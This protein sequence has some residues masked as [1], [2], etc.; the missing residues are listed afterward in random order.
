MNSPLLQLNSN[1]YNQYLEFNQRIKQIRE[2]YP[3]SEN[4]YPYHTIEIIPF[5]L[6]T[7]ES[8][9]LKLEDYIKDK[10]ILDLGCGDGDL[11]FFFEF[12]GAKTVI[13][14]D[15]APTNFNGLKGFKLIKEKL[16]SNVILIEGDIHEFNFK[17][18]P[19]IDTAFVFGFLYHSKHPLWILENLCKKTQFLFLTTKVFDH[20]DAYA[21]FYD[22][23]ESNN[24]STNWWCFS[25]K[26][27]VLML[28]RFKSIPIITQRL[29]D[30]IGISHPVDPALD[31]RLFIF[32]AVQERILAGKGFTIFYS[33]GFYHDEGGWRWMADEGH[34][35]IQKIDKTRSN[36][37]TLDLRCG[38][39]KWYQRFPF[40]VS[41]FQGNDLLKI[42]HFESDNQRKKVELSIF[43]KSQTPIVIR[44]VSSESFIPSVLGINDD[45]RRLSVQIVQVSF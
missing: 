14:M 23:G 6:S 39:S 19:N 8:Y 20:E 32:T 27:L 16:K 1:I 29:D 22:I 25:P 12:I 11:S 33:E 21:Y 10:I 18:I 44:L 41:I 40:D 43:T 45:N 26:T 13:A 9:D 36:I 5:I 28:K 15:Y 30:H 38:A 7:L 35:I 3:L 2:E 42:V 31:G 4:Y 24:D 37:L 17:D 34:L